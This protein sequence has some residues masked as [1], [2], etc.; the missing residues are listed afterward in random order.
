MAKADGY[1]VVFNNQEGIEAPYGWDRECEGALEY[2]EPVVVFPD[3][4]AAQ[5]AI[6][7][8]V[9][10]ARLEKE[11]GRPANDDFLPPYR[12]HVKIIPVV[13]GY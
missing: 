5:R 8:S 9:A 4:K 6:R 11:Q 2:I 13:R 12:K 10:K 1:I 3:R 7:I